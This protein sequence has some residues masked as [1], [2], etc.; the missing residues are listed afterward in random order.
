MTGLA[1]SLDPESTVGGLTTKDT[2]APYEAPER[3]PASD[4]RRFTPSGST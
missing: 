1:E 4:P 2:S 3:P